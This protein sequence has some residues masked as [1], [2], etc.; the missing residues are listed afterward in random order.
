[1]LKQ[2]FQDS[3]SSKRLTLMSPADSSWHLQVPWDSL[4]YAAPHCILE[5]LQGIDVIK[6]VWRGSSVTAVALGGWKALAECPQHMLHPGITV[7]IYS[8]RNFHR[9][10]VQAKW[11]NNFVC[12]LLTFY[13]ESHIA[14]G[15]DGGVPS[16][17]S[18]SPSLAQKTLSF[19]VHV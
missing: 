4:G 5:V 1:M 10:T 2:Q 3:V 13:F 6:T 18:F 8:N 9:E 15:T 19:N 17:L 16:Y 11:D 14:S 7:L 12:A